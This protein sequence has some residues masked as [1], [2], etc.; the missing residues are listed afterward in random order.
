MDKRE[1]WTHS[2]PPATHPCNRM[3]DVV[4][5]DEIDDDDDDKVGEN[6]PKIW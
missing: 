5:G 2:R 3:D 4:V 1:I 6:G